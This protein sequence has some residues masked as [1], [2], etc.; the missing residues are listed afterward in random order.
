MGWKGFLCREPDEVHAGITQDLY[1]N[2]DS[3]VWMKYCQRCGSAVV[4]LGF[5]EFWSELSISYGP[6][7]MPTSLGTLGLVRAV[8]ELSYSVGSNDSTIL[9]PET[10]SEAI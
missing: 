10:C 8:S 1:R 3:D 5:C 4:A 9:S 6:L 7:T 2:F